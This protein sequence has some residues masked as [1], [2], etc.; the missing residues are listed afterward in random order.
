MFLTQKPRLPR[1]PDEFPA[2]QLFL[3]ALVR[4]SE[5][6]ALTSIF[7]YA[8]KLVLY[9]NVG[10]PSD[11]AFYA[12]I[13][14][15]AFS[16]AEAVTGLFWGSLSDRIGRKPVLLIGTVGTFISLIILGV[17]ES[18]W[19][20]LLGRILG[21]LLN[22]NI[23]VIQTMVGELAQNPKHETRAF[24]VM[25]FVWSIG[26][27]IG[28]AL[29]GYFADPSSSWPLMFPSDGLFAKLPYLLPNLICAVLLLF[30]M[31][32]AYFFLHETHPDMQPWST[33]DDLKYTTAH[34]PL[35]PTAGSMS[36]APAD[37]SQESYGTFDHVQI[38]NKPRSTEE[39]KSLSRASS[40]S[41]STREK[42]FTWPV[43]VLVTA[44]GIYTYHSMTYDHLLPIFLQD[45]RFTPDVHPF[46]TISTVAGGLG[47]S[48]QNVGLIMSI[49]GIIAMP[50]QGIIFPLM[51][52]WLG[53]WRLFVI[54]TIG[55]P[56]AYILVPYL[57]LLPP[58]WVYTGIYTCLF[59]RNVFSILAY[60][61]LL[62]L[63]KEASPSPSM[64][65]KI[66]GL[67]ASTGGACRTIASPVAGALYGAGSKMHWAALP[68]WASAVVALLGAAQV[69]W[70][71]RTK[72]R[73]AHV[74][75]AAAFCEEDEEE[76][77]AVRKGARATLVEVADA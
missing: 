58:T 74:R 72:N 30:S 53:V 37:I 15:A 1:N 47:L 35:I 12:G 24:A 19:I 33:R 44:L 73:T 48:T 57:V 39:R 20:A 16:L 43:I 54:V 7:P 61:L 60:P 68:W 34:T 76:V 26:T 3:L 50:V 23:G 14:I 10:R 18:F 22:G 4:V 21:G 41:S 66:N 29:G 49:N 17:A 63:I 40:T 59:V 8:W 9:Y 42:T 64:L 77:G 28:P 62:I 67:A 46:T 51:A 75:T 52:S 2:T 69:P 45:V 55:H 38:T 56:L 5:P 31:F 65:G 11:A 32:A 6:I 36:S 70:I 71:E 13:L 25:P 27:I